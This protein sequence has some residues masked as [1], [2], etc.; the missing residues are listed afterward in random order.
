M[1]LDDDDP[2]WRH[3]DGGSGHRDFPEWSATDAR[4]A[5][6]FYAAV[7][8]RARVILDLLID[9]PGEQLGAVWLASQILDETSSGRALPQ[10]VARAFRDMQA[11]QAASGRRYPFYWWRGNGTGPAMA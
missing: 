3:H 7:T 5:A 1:T 10:L 8:G 11:A 6:A 9:H 2:L 4:R